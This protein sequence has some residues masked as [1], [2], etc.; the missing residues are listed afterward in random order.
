MSTSASQS[1]E[2]GSIVALCGGVGGAKLALGLQRVL[3]KN[4]TLIVNTGDD[5]EHH[6]LMISPDIDTVLYTLSGL[7]DQERGWGRADES[8]NFMASLAELGGETWFQLGD[9]DLALHVL[10]TQRLRT[11]ETLTSFTSAIARQLR[12]PATI[13]PMSDQPVRTIIETP[14]GDL[15]FQDYFVK[16]RCEPEVR[17]IRFDGAEAAHV[18][19][20]VQKA[21][22][23][24]TLPAVIICPSNPFLSIDPVLATPG[25]RK[26]LD[27]VDAPIVAISPI[28]GGTAV[29]GPT[30]KI[31][32]QLHM[33]PT[34]KTIAEHYR[35]II[36]GLIIDKA[37]VADAGSVDVA[38][39]A[40]RTLMTSDAD[41]ERLAH[42]ALAFANELRLARVSR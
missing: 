12:I 13:L 31:M 37:D 4:L 41:K 33:P 36:D 8:W 34:S 7:S 20:A 10:R 38:T 21:L 26:L 3:G 17:A 6:S 5:F 25:M 29:K 11:G 19:D 24:P 27:H 14:E 16:R 28:I 30:A 18:S 23:S 35:G 40:T 22:Q 9:K 32:A 15:P 39:M 2:D 1:N 42:A